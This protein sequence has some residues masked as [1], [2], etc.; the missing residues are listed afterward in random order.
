MRF[1]KARK[2]QLSKNGLIIFSAKNFFPY[3][4]GKP[5]TKSPIYAECPTILLLMNTDFHGSMVH[6]SKQIS[7]FVLSQ[8]LGMLFIA[9]LHA[10]AVQFTL[11]MF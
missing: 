3:M 5:K 6:L 10:H 4:D 11:V 8:I 7:I 9:L 2:Q 1:A